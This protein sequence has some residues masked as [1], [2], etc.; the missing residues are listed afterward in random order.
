MR[1]ER[2]PLR[3]LAATLLGALI[4]ETL[5][6]MVAACGVYGFTRGSI[7]SGPMRLDTVDWVAATAVS[8]AGSYFI[9]TVFHKIRRLSADFDR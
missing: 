7:L 1:N 2:R 5:G 6:V 4:I 9:R 3:S 8:V